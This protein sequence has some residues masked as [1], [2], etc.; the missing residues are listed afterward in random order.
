MDGS[1]HY[2]EKDFH[3]LMFEFRQIEDSIALR[4][5]NDVLMKMNK[6][7]ETLINEIEELNKKCAQ[8]LQDLNLIREKYSASRELIVGK[9]KRKSMQNIIMLNNAKKDFG[10]IKRRK[11]S[12]MEAQEILN[13]YIER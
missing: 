5:E 12:D 6:D 7:R 3:D 8:N 13:K 9:F 1:M 11:C 10:L 2:N 4:K